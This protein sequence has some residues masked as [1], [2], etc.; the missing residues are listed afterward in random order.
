MKVL[1]RIFSIV[2]HSLKVLN[3]H[4]SDKQV[5]IYPP[6]E[7]TADSSFLIISFFFYF[8]LAPLID[9]VE[10]IF[11][12]SFSVVGIAIIWLSFCAIIYSATIYNRK[13]EDMIMKYPIKNMRKSYI[14]ICT[15]FMTIVIL[16][17][18]L[19]PITRMF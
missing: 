6:N 4:T 17:I 10:I 2:F 9:I 12:I 19:F 7:Q 3:T 18:T 13:W 14:W 5:N 8:F 15:G 11:T 16:F 1:G